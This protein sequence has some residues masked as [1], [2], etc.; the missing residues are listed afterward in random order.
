MPAEVQPPELAR[1][2]DFAERPRA[3]DWSLRAALTRYAQPQPQRV[4][5]L[6]THVR[7][8]EFAL[9]PHLKSIERDGPAVWEAVNAGEGAPSGDLVV[10]LLRVMTELDG[11]G[12]VL[13]TWAADP[14]GERPDAAVDAV[15]ASVG[16]RLDEL[17]VPH[18][19]RQRPPGARSRG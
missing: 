18:E 7:R 2:V 19:Q 16:A 4:S 15:I 5:D 13:A 10:E 11:L 1:L 12:D 9:R 3:Q 8:I 6:L 14:T 17:G